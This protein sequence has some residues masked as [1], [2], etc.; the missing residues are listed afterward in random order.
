MKSARL[1]RVPRRLQKRAE[2]PMKARKMSARARLHAS[3]AVVASRV[4]AVVDRLL[5]APVLSM[6]A[7]PRRALGRS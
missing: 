5:P 6:R 7:D 4:A 2:M 1:P 3:A